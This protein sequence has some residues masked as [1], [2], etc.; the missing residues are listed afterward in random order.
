MKTDT[1]KRT[2]IC[3][4]APDANFDEQ[5]ALTALEQVEIP[6]TVLKDDPAASET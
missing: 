6:G 4:L 3:E 2:A 5:A 1:S